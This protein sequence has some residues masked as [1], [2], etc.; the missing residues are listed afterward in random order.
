MEIAQTLIRC[1]ADINKKGT[2][3]GAPMQIAAEQGN[4]QLTLGYTSIELLRD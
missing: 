3:G 2:F 1:G 4:L